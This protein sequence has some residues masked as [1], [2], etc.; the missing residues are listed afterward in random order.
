MIMNSLENIL[1]ERRDTWWIM[2]LLM[3]IGGG[4]AVFYLTWAAAQNAFFEWGPYRS[5]I[6]S[7]PF[8][9]AWWPISPAFLL[10]WIPIG[11]RLTCY[12]ARRVYYRAAFLDPAACSVE[13]PYRKSYRGESAFP[14]ILQNLHRYFLYLALGLLA[15]HW[16]ELF[17]T[18]F[19]Q[20]LVDIYIGV[21]TVLLF[22]DTLALT[23]YVGGCHSLRHL[24]G[25]KRD[26][27]SC[28]GCS[29]LSYSLWRKVS[30]LNAFHNVWF[31]VSLFS[32]ILADL[33]IRLLAMGVITADPHLIFK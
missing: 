24:I 17:G 1:T 19:G 29:K 12:Y 31:W 15:W 33:Y 32:I 10:L 21:G 18:I 14:F 5:P 6:Y 20:E 3:L 25:G 4:L 8:V 28:G 9:P 22:L 27:F 13:E 11:F 7:A 23:F 26:C 30:R 2:P 16:Y